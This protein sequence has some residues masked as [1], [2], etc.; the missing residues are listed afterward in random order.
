MDQKVAADRFL[1]FTDS[2]GK[3]QWHRIDANGKTVQQCH[4]GFDDR[5]QCVDD[6]K[7]HGYV[8]RPEAKSS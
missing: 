3:Q 8:G 5:Y 2:E 1:F 4:R 7:R 6:A